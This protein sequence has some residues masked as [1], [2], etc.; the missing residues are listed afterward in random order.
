[1]D[2]LKISIVTPSYNQG[3]Y[4][5]KTILSVLNQNYSNL[6]Y[7][8]IDGGSTDNSIEIIKKYEKHLTYW[9]SEKDDGQSD[10]INKGLSRCTGDIIAWLNSDDYYE[11]D[12]FKNVMSTFAQ[13]PSAGLLYGNCRI[14]YVDAEGKALQQK[15]ISP[16]NVNGFSLL[17]YWKSYFLPPQ[18]SMFWKKSIQDETRLLDKNL[19]YAMDM[20]FWLQLSEHT[21]IVK[22][23]FLL[24]NYLVHTNSKSG[25]EGGFSKFKSEW[26]LV[27]ESHLK[28]KSTFVNLNYYI[29]KITYQLGNYKYKKLPRVFLRYIVDVFKKLTGVK[30]IG[31][32]KGK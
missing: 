16:E 5:E 9:V 3:Q 6:E 26:K 18:P 10:G 13:Y 12:T 29:I 4:L 23:N 1:M 19:N 15:I 25:S 7:I 30:K 32:L 14:I 11:P 20:D 28:S 17:H 21:Q 24:S 2:A 27:S 22:A 8:I 31:I